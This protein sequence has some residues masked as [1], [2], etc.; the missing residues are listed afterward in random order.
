MNKIDFGLNTGGV[1][2]NLGDLSIRRRG[3]RAT[4]VGTMRIDLEDMVRSEPKTD[5]V[6]PQ[7]NDSR[8]TRD[9]LRAILKKDPNSKEALC[10]IAD[11][12]AAEGRTKEAIDSYV[13]LLDID[14]GFRDAAYKASELDPN[15]S[16]RVKDKKLFFE[17]WGYALLEQG[18]N[19]SARRRF[20]KALEVDG[21][22]LGALYG[23]ARTYENDKRFVEAVTNYVKVAMV[24]SSFKDTVKRAESIDKKVF[25]KV[26]GYECIAAGQYG[27]A[28]MKFRKALEID[29]RSN[30][31]MYGIANS[32]EL[33]GKSNE[34][35][36]HY[37]KIAMIDSSF[38][39]VVERGE[40]IDKKVFYKIWGNECIAA[41]QYSR[42]RMKFRKS[43]EVDP[44]SYT[45]LEGLA[46]AYELD[47][48][49]ED[50][51]KIRA[52]LSK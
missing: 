8:R 29:P 49:K 24:N 5:D 28:R 12:Y 13:K 9:R 41:G 3:V 21:K 43:L 18:K 52:K 19:D 15:V 22:S 40:G 1:S 16:D 50:A 4:P 44:H 31:T 2:L 25:Y 37:V 39:D 10:E 20:R 30:D 27:R 7:K 35:I 32:Y 6:T 38:R 17:S 42:A 14:P 26:W 33:E 36:G 11:S 51:V 48:R 47:G 45:A 46:R 34:A 23:V